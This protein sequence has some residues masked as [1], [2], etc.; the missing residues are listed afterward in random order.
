MSGQLAVIEP[1]SATP[2]ELRDYAVYVRS[3]I[4]DLDADELGI[5]EVALVVI[6]KRLRRIG[7]DATE[8]ERSRILAMQRLGELIQAEPEQRGGDRRGQSTN[9][10]TLTQAEKN[11]RSEARL[12][13]EQKAAAD[14]AAAKE[15]AT[16]NRAL[17]EAR[18]ARKLSSIAAQNAARETAAQEPIPPCQVIYADPPWRYDASETPD[19]RR[20]EN[21][22]PTMT[23]PDIKALAA[24]GE[25]P[26]ADDAVLFLWATSPKL[27]EALEVMAAWGF[28]YRTCAAW[29]KDRIGMG[30]YF[31]QRHELLLIGKRGSLPVP[32]PSDRP[33][34]VVSAP[35]TEH[36]AKPGVFYELIEQMYPG[37]AYCEMFL[38]G[39]PREGWY[40]WGNEAAGRAS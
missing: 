3:V 23:L 11:R 9:T 35:R 12:L 14:A 36:S 13:A 2:L 1:R 25:V 6:A 37:M 7:E 24:Q 38:R 18:R 19:F 39:E 26:A 40:G 20:I 22:Y 28:T 21:Q 27:P 15:K 33:D 16:L 30:Y 8:A 32:E 17:K 10:R 34:S 31:R 4:P 5:L 29:V